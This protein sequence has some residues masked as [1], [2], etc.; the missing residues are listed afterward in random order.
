MVKA[1]A[2]NAGLDAHDGDTVKVG[3]LG[4]PLLRHLRR[5]AYLADAQS[6]CPA[7]A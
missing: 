3:A 1:G 5:L 2:G 7:P 6:D 4:K